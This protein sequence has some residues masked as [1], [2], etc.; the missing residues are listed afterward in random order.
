M[1]HPGG[2]DVIEECAGKDCTERFED[3]DHMPESI[4]D[5]KQY[6]IGDYEGKKQSL[7][8]QKAKQAKEHIKLRKKERNLE[9]GRQAL[10][11]F[12]FTL[13]AVMILYFVYNIRLGMSTTNNTDEML[14]EEMVI[15]NK[16]N[17]G[18]K[19]DI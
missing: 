12:V 7:Q 18:V 17:I 14:R 13:L 9:Q 5:L 10:G 1:D 6:Y 4:R 8:E 2:W 15:G 11:I 3:G 19:T 16:G